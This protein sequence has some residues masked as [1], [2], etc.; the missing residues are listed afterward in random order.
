MPACAARELV[1]ATANSGGSDG[2]W[3]HTPS[4]S[5]CDWCS[6]EFVVSK[7]GGPGDYNGGPR[8]PPYQPLVLLEKLRSEARGFVVVAN[9]GP[10]Q[11]G[12]RKRCGRHVRCGDQSMSSA[13]EPTFDDW[14]A[15]AEQPEPSSRMGLTR[16]LIARFGNKF[17]T[18]SLA[19]PRK[20]YVNTRYTQMWCR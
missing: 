5:T 11:G 19:Y 8:W 13:C 10:D 14:L 1:S 6:W 4:S 2:R 12:A 7:A 20:A 16:A 9:I 17:S 15:R 18:K 3:Y